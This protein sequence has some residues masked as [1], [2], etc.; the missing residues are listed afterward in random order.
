A[1]ARPEAEVLL[2]CPNPASAGDLF[3]EMHP[4]L[5]V[6]DTLWRACTASPRR[7][8][9]GVW[10]HVETQVLAAGRTG[11]NTGLGQLARAASIHL[12]GGGYL[13][14]IWRD[15]VGLV[16]GMVSTRRI[17]GARL[18]GT[19]L[20]LLPACDGVPELARAFRTFDYVSCRDRSSARQFGLPAGLDDLFLGLMTDLPPLR[21]A[22]DRARDVMVCLQEDLIGPE[23]FALAA[24]LLR[25]RI[26]E[27]LDEGKSVG[28]VEA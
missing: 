18:Y 23:S 14:A 15:R 9:A 19:G 21:P 27:C 11:N 4:H 17:S 2:D 22:R 1:R 24:G 26:K 13:N 7:D 6:T 8:P 28:Y 12:I 10:E 16:A 20:G 5:Q 25:A 3:R